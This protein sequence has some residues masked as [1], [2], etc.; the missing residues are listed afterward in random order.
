MESDFSQYDKDF[1]GDSNIA[2]KVIE[3]PGWWKPDTSS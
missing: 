3:N 2:V 1:D